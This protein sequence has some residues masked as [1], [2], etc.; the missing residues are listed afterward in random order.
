MELIPA[1][2]A[3]QAHT[4]GSSLSLPKEGNL[5]IGRG[6]RANLKTGLVCRQ[7]TCKL[8]Q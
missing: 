7:S 6:V 8:A 2:I 4:E 5:Q 1:G 3:S